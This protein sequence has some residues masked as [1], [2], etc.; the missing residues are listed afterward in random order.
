MAQGGTVRKCLHF[1]L[2][3]ISI[4]ILSAGFADAQARLDVYFGMGTAR[5]GSSNEY[6]DLLD[7][8][9]YSISP[10]LD[11]AFGKFGVGV[12]LTPN[13]GVGGEV[14]LRFRQG[15]YGGAGYRPVLYDFNGIWTP[16][17]SDR[18]MPEFQGGLGVFDMRFYDPTYFYYDYWSGNYTNYAGSSRHL[19]LHAGAGL[20]IYVTPS[21]FI[22]PQVDY[23][24]VRNNRWFKDK[25]IPAYTLSIGYSLERTW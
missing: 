20:R 10:A 15:D 21:I 24:W 13:M 9:V 1:A 5:A 6:F 3:A 22:R 23:H 14:T 16:S 17:L 7:T 12:M 2:I 18:V 19:Q 8:G 4:L 11:G 25:S